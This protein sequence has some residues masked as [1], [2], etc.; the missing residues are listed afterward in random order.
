MKGGAVRDDKSPLKEAMDLRN[1]LQEPLFFSDT[2]PP[3]FS[4]EDIAVEDYTGSML[5]FC[6]WG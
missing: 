2:P 3:S 5:D 1:A 6:E 4:W